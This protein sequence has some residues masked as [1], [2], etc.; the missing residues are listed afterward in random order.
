[1]SNRSR[2]DTDDDEDEQFSKSTLGKRV[3]ASF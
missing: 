2:A 3:M 1:M